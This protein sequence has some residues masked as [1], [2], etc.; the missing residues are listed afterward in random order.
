MP[1]KLTENMRIRDA[2]SSGFHDFVMNIG[3]GIGIRPDDETVKIPDEYIHRGNLIDLIRFVYP[4][5]NDP[6]SCASAGILATTH[7]DVDEINELALSMNNSVQNVFPSLDSVEDQ[8]A[9]HLYP[10][11]FLNTYCVSKRMPST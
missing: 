10:P 9:A 3:N 1:L 7:A 4:N 6:L 11:E 5:I 8:A 2:S